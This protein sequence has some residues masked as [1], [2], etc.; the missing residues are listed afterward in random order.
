[1]DFSR[2]KKA[3]TELLEALFG[4]DVL[5]NPN[6]SGTPDRMAKM[7]MSMLWN[8]DEI[9]STVIQALSKKFPT[10]YE[11]IVLL[12]NISSISFCPHHMLP[13]EYTIHLAYIPGFDNGAR[14]EDLLE[15]TVI[16]ASKPERVCQALGKY[17]YLQEDLTQ[18]VASIIEEAIHPKGIAVVVKGRHG[19]MRV[20]GIKNPCANMVTSVMT[21]AFNTP[22]SKAEFFEL[23][24]IGN[25]NE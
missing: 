9:E 7:Y 6:F 16:G 21:G 19:C 20:R 2:V 14:G 5:Y 8:A 17:P 24:K 11:G 22:N 23:L 13:V 10:E 1:M 4:E 18:T 15:R 12:P 3:S 25:A